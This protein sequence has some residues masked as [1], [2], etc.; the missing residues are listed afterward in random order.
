MPA[1]RLHILN[2]RFTT[3]EILLWNGIH[4]NSYTAETL[5]YCKLWLEGKQEFELKTSGSTGT[6]KI[7]HI[8]RSQIEAS[9][10][11]TLHFFNLQPGDAVC[12]PLSIHVIGGQMMLYRSMIGG[13]DLYV[14]PPSKQLDDL[15]TTIDYAF[16]PIA[17]LQLFEVLTHQPEK[18]AVLNKL[19]HLLI[20]GSTIT[21]ALFKQIQ[22][23]LSCAVWQSYGMTETVSHIA[24]RSIHPVTAESYTLLEHIEAGIDERSCLK[25]KAAVSNNEWIQTNDC[26]ELLD[27]RHFI[28]QG[29]MDFTVNSGGVKIQVEPI[30]KIIDVLF[31]ELD[32]HAAFFV[33]G[34][35][36]NALGDRLILAVDRIAIDSAQ[37]DYLFKKLSEVLPRYHVPK[38]IHTIVF[39]YTPSGKIDRKKSLQ[40]I[41]G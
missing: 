6:P 2:E 14:I 19:K 3:E 5:T 32:I 31:S 9:A 11:A 22:H 16:M 4:A 33:G 36:D 40:K 38:D 7:I 13:L 37:H 8:Q 21:D 10:T 1:F 26:V 34:V 39:E 30:E 23:S 12:C 41:K 29:R 18:I 28:F 35:A 20:G 15:D 25:I 27:D 24:L 17:A